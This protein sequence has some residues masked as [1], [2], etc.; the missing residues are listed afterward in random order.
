MRAK[1][2]DQIAK[3]KIAA[4]SAQAMGSKKFSRCAAQ[5]LA[6]HPQV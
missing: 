3:K 4:P 2:R 6:Q 1:L 5:R